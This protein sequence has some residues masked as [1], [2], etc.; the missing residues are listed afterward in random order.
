MKFILLL[1][2]ASF[3]FQLKAQVTDFKVLKA[4]KTSAL[5]IEREEFR[6]VLNETDVLPEGKQFLVVIG[7]VSYTVDGSKRQRKAVLKHG[8]DLIPA[9]GELESSQKATLGYGVKGVFSEGLNYFSAIFIVDAALQN[10]TIEINDKPFEL[11]DIKAGTITLDCYPTAFVVESKYMDEVITASTYNKPNN[12]SYDK[13]ISP[14][15]GKLLSVDFDLEFCENADYYT[16]NG[17]YYSPR[18]LQLKSKEGK[19]H[20]C[21]GTLDGRKRF[22][23]L[24]RKSTFG[25]KE[26][27][28]G[29][30]HIFLVPAEGEYDLYYLGKKLATVQ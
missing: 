25:K 16:K 9:L 15:A 29:G 13:K 12:Q 26:L 2:A 11:K 22:K 14:K 27:S 1:V 18:Y 8:E 5:E 28:G 3:Y 17:F 20:E 6:G 23:R 4:V 7:V 30:V 19:M 10:T 24:F 21:I